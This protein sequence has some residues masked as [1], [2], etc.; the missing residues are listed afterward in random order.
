MGDVPSLP[1]VRLCISAGAP[2]SSAVAKSFLEKFRQPIHSFY[3]ASECGG[4][5]Y[6]RCGTNFEDGLVG[7]RIQGVDDEFID[8]METASQFRVRG[9]AVSDGD[10]AEPEEQN[11]G[12]GPVDQ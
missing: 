9:A 8:R 10:F 7:Q 1:K 12:N 2:L 6:D 3:G 5:C 4:V 11:R